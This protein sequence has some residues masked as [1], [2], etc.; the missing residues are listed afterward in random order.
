MSLKV[1]EC[2]YSLEEFQLRAAALLQTRQFFKSSQILFAAVSSMQLP[3]D[4]TYDQ[5]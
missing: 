3:R 1:H 5:N 2:A 4:G